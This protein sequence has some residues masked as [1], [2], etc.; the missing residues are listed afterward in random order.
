MDA[1]MSPASLEEI[2]NS[3]IGEIQTDILKYSQ[4]P[5]IFGR[6]RNDDRGDPGLPTEQEAMLLVARGE[7]GEFPEE[8]AAR[9]GGGT[10]S[11]VAYSPDGKLASVQK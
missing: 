8:P 6:Q 2:D 11:Q 10:I 3:G 4:I 7:A 9:L 5:A 1:P